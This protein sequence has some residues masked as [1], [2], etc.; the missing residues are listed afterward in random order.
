M[1]ITKY[2]DA[3]EQWKNYS[4]GSFRFGTLR[5][6]SSGEDGD[7]DRFS[8]Q[9]EG[10]AET[11]FG[12]AGDSISNLELGNTSIRE[13]VTFAPAPPGTPLHDLWKEHSVPISYRSHFD[14]NVFCASI[15]PYDPDHHRAMRFGVED[16]SEPY[17][18]NPELTGWA[19]INV[20]KFLQA[21]HRWVRKNS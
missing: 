21:I 18:G 4:K 3:S 14:S 7:G 17:R 12:V 8:D 9:T 20:D 6:Y 10:K 2:F 15:G 11:H 5:S 1:L 19:E 13:F 16:S